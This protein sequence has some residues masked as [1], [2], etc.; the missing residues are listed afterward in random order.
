MAIW[1]AP[2]NKNDTFFAN[3]TAATSETLTLGTP[4]SGDLLICLVAWTGAVTV[5]VSD[6]RSNAWAS[7]TAL[8]NGSNHCQLWY[9]LAANGA[10]TV[11]ITAAFSGAGATQIQ[12]SAAEYPVNQS[13]QN[14]S[15][16]LDV[17]SGT[18]GSSAA[19]SWGMVVTNW[20]D[21]LWVGYGDN[22][23]SNTWTQGSGWTL[24]STASARRSAIEDQLNTSSIGATVSFTTGSNAAWECGLAA[25]KVA[26][27]GTS[28]QQMATT[29]AAMQGNVWSCVLNRFSFAGTV[30]GTTP[31][32]GGGGASPGVG[33]IFPN[34]YA[35]N[36]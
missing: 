5:T 22:G 36:P 19:P 28:V 8:S 34:G 13:T 23:V 16:S 32:S 17:G 18:T 29:N 4:I 33:Q 1:S 11:T 9:C 20:Q 24:R 25:F 6:N 10:G 2:T 15:V 3:G 21:E 14:P 7:L 35:G 30:L 27:T 12:L 31:T 26:S